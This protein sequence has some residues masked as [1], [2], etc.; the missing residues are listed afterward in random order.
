MKIA[1]W[2]LKKI[3]D[4]AS[5]TYQEDCEVDLESFTEVTE[6]DGSEQLKL[7]P[8]DEWPFDLVLTS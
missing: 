8:D 6:V 7:L 1:L 2:E 3:V 4:I 5:K